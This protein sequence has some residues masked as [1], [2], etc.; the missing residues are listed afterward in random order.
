M[1]EAWTYQEGEVLDENGL[2]IAD[3]ISEEDG[4]LVAAAPL[5]ASAIESALLQLLQGGG[6][7]GRI[8]E[9][10][11]C[12]KQLRT[13][14]R[15]AKGMDPR[16]ED[17]VEESPSALRARISL[18]REALEHALPKMESDWVTI[19]GEWGP[20]RPIEQAPDDE[21]PEIIMAR[22]AL[23]ATEAAG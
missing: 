13:A 9:R 21:I 4:P 8:F 2:T 7:G 5:M 22:A 6:M 11:D 14:Y 1:A 16:P 23:K 20:R 18:L 10:D 15:A 12:V 17:A 3:M 19:D